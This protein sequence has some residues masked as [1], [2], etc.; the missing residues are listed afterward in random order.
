MKN[1]NIWVTYHKDDQLEQYPL[2][3]EEMY[4]W[5]KGNKLNVTGENI[6]H[7]NAFYSEIVTLYWVWKNK[8]KSSV[9]GFCHY[10]RRFPKILDVKDGECQVLAMNRNTDVFA[11]YKFAHN[12][13]DL[14]KVIDILNDLYGKDNKYSQYLLHGKTFIPFCCFL[15]N[16]ADF[17]KLADF[18]FKVL[19]EFD[20]RCGLNLESCK[21]REKAEKDFRY[22][23]VDYQQRMMGFLAER[24]ISGYLL[25]EMDILCINKI[26][27]MR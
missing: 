7:L 8:V 17:E 14:Y 21:Y 15:M 10:R 3:E 2:P 1:V 22:D 16:W 4:H 19:F 12:Y 5:F 23:N 27:R 26:S 24:L 11:H 9:V 18:L 13:H 20:R 25:N 6:N